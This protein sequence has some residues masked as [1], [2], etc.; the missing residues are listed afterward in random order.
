MKKVTVIITTLFIML[1]SNY[2]K[3]APSGLAVYAAVTATLSIA[4]ASTELYYKQ[5][6]RRLLQK[7]REDTLEARSK[8]LELEKEGKKCQ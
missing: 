1:F 2:S 6:E 5:Q 8:A 3:A 7:Y 4:V